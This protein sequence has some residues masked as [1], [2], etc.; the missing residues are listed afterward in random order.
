MQIFAESSRDLGDRN[1]YRFELQLRDP[2]SVSKPIL[3]RNAE[4]Q[5]SLPHGG[6]DFE[7]ADRGCD[8]GRPGRCAFDDTP[9]RCRQPWGITQPPYQGVRIEDDQRF[10]S[11]SSAEITGSKGW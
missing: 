8:R 6:G 1:R 5:P 7:H 2:V 10:I 11:H 9:G 3:Q 4:L